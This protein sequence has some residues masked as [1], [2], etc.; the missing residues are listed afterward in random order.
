MSELSNLQGIRPAP[1]PVAP[2]VRIRRATGYMWLSLLLVAASIAAAFFVGPV[3]ATYLVALAI[4][5]G[6][7]S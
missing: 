6:V 5:V 3:W 2:E 1:E 4:Y 7:T